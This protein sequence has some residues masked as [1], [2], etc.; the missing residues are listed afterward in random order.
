MGGEMQQQN[1]T[2]TSVRTTQMMKINS[3]KPA[4]LAA[5]FQN[6]VSNLRATSGK[7]LSSEQ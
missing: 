5:G 2:I 4:Q 1:T 6:L 3:N 7:N